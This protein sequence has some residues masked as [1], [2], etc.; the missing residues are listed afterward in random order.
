MCK[1]GLLQPRYS[2]ELAAIGKAAG[3]V[4]RL[5]ILGGPPA[6]DCIVVFQRKADGIHKLVTAGARRAVAM[7]SHAFAYRDRFPD[8]GILLQGRNHCRWRWRRHSENV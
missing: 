2:F 8:A 4:D 3:D 7:L 5:A 1:Q 6:A